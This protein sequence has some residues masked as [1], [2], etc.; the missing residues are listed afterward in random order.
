M[1]PVLS[2]FSPFHSLSSASPALSL[3]LGTTITH[4]HKYSFPLDILI[5]P[6]SCTIERRNI[7]LRSTITHSN[8]IR[9]N[10]ISIH[11]QMEKSK[12]EVY[13]YQMSRCIIPAI[14]HRDHSPVVEAGFVTMAT[15]FRPSSSL[16]YQHHD[17]CSL[18]KKD[19]YP[20]TH[21]LFT[22]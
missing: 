21:C 12:A 3:P 7:R 20:H 11:L 2:F 13:L 16:H 15:P 1:S 17:P 9:L 6:N 22:F 19:M 4:T 18:R 8:Y 10:P 14:K 5:S